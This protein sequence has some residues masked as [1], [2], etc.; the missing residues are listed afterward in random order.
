MFINI[1]LKFMV[2]FHYQIYIYIYIYIYICMFDIMDFSSYKN[3][4][5][6]NRAQT[7]T[8]HVETI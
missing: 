6:V 1:F 3:I 5:V 2:I 8:Q 4:E 7:E